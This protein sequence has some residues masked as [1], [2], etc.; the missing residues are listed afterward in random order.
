LNS[1][2]RCVSVCVCVCECVCVSVCVRLEV[3]IYKHIHT[4][5]RIHAI[6]RGDQSSEQS[7]G[8]QADGERRRVF[9]QQ[10][11]AEDAAGL[12]DRPHKLIRGGDDLSERATL[13][14]YTAVTALQVCIHTHM[15]VYVCLVATYTYAYVYSHV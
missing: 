7:P 13:R 10:P 6:A 5:T 9:G 1:N 11:T 8:R 3:C 2:G 14:S 15:H 12:S 4:H